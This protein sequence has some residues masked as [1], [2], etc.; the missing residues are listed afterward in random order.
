MWYKRIRTREARGMFKATWKQRF[1]SAPGE[2]RTAKMESGGA[3]QR[4]FRRVTVETGGALRTGVKEWR[5]WAELQTHDSVFNL[6]VAH[7]GE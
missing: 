1:R 2:F 3:G 6:R 7:P 5:C 4:E